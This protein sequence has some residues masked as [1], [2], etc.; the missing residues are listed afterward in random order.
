MLAPVLKELTYHAVNFSQYAYTHPK[1][2]FKVNHV[3]VSITFSLHLKGGT[4][5]KE[6]SEDKEVV[7]KRSRRRKTQQNGLEATMSH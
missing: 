4:D 7:D 2:V 5:R 1:K 6:E 3:D